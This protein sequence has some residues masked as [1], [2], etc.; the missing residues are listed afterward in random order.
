MTKTFTSLNS[1]LNTV[2][3]MEQSI[4]SAYLSA[5]N[6]TIVLTYP[7]V[8]LSTCPFLQHPFKLTDFC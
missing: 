7:P 5:I 6:K 3:S 2:L 1:R 8:H 4:K